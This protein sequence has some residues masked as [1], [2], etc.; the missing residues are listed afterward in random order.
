MQILVPFSF[1]KDSFNNLRLA[2]PSQDLTTFDQGDWR[3][4]STNDCQPYTSKG[5]SARKVNKNVRIWPA[6]LSAVASEVKPLPQPS[7]EVALF[8]CSI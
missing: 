8:P 1:P 2:L 5:M 7:G 3:E 4:K 6:F